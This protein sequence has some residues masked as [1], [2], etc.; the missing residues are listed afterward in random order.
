MTQDPSPTSEITKSQPDDPLLACLEEV[1]A[2]HGMAV[3]RDAVLAGLPL[4]GGRLTPGL[5]LRAAHRA[6]F[7]ARLVERPIHRLPKS[8]LPAIVILDGN[9]AGILS[10]QGRNGSVSFRLPGENQPDQPQAELKKRYSGFSVLLQPHVADVEERRV[11]PKMWFWHTM[12]KF[13]GYYSR[14]VPAALMVSLLALVMPLFIMMVYDR[15]VPNDATET[16]WVLATG[17]VLVF[18]FEYLLRLVRGR[19]LERAGREMDM[20]LA[21]TLY[22]QILSI[23]MQARPPSA[24]VLAARTKA[25]EVLRD[26]FMSA[27][28]LAIVDLPFSIFMITAVFFVAGPVGLILIASATIAILFG[29]FVQVPLRRSVVAS[30]EESVERQ[31]M[32]SETINGLESVKGAGAEGALQQRFENMVSTSAEKDVHMHWYGLLGTSTTAALINLTTVAVVVTSVYRVQSGA[33]TMGGMIAAVMLS[34]RT[35]TPIAMVSGLMTRL[36]QALQALHSL[37]TVMALPRETGGHRK[38]VQRSEFDFHYK[39]ENVTVRYP[40]QHIPA[41]NNVNIQ[42]RQGERIALLGRMG[43]GKST[44]L[45]VLAKIYTPTEGAVLL[46]G[47]DLAQYHPAVVRNEIGFLAQDATVFRGSIRENVA[48]SARSA[49]DEE[50]IQAIRMAGLEEFVRKNP[51]GIHAPVGEQGSLLSGGQRRALVLARCFLTRPRLLL[52]DEPTAN[53]DP[54]SEKEFIQALKRYL[55]QDV[56]HTLVLATHKT[57]LLAL[58]DHLIVLD[59]GRIFAAGPKAAVL[60]K[61]SGQPAP[62]SPKPGEDPKSKPAA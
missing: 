33:M 38:F 28:M 13:R 48:L 54:Q 15:V 55:E 12:W 57:G 34:S 42:I 51:R 47:V 26:F 7:R 49:T 10:P 11:S 14:L 35:M 41:L 56:R 18:C 9:R 6:G 50:V 45:R 37:N 29:C 62:H 25:Y 60:A 52:L 17:V 23:E 61:L 43:S 8:V 30:S 24:G 32:V 31:A 16:L 36:Q 58:V 20:V 2:S 19:V 21:S 22:E 44:L 39:F 4:E 27:T 53:M 46:D 59:E 3:N 1:A 5:L 40:G